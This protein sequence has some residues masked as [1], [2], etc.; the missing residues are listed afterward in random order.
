MKSQRPTM[1]PSLIKFLAKCKEFKESSYSLGVEIKPV[2]L[3][4][5]S[6]DGKKLI[7]EINIQKFYSLYKNF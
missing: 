5:V 3:I 6:K 7:K 4:A 2:E 1:S